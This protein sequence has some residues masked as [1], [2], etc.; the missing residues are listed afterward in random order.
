VSL[1]DAVQDCSGYYAL[2]RKSNDGS[3]IGR[4]L[5]FY[6]GLRWWFEE[7]ILNDRSCID[8]IALV[9][10]EKDLTRCNDHTWSME[11]RSP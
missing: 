7:H 11:D 8:R 4:Q 10:T 6:G 3:V 5:D 1:A 2:A 9:R